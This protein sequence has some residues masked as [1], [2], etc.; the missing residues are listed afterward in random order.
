MSVY[1]YAIAAADT[2]VPESE[3]LHGEPVRAVST[4]ALVAAVST[5]DDHAHLGG[6]SDLWAHEQVVEALMSG[7]DVLPARFGTLLGDDEIVRQLLIARESEFLEALA[8]V[9]GSYEV[10]VRAALLGPRTRDTAELSG[11]EYLRLAAH[12][13]RLAKTLSEQLEHALRPLARA[14]RIR[15]GRQPGRLVESAWLIDRERLAEF[16]DRAAELN[17]STM[18]AELLCTGPWPPYSFVGAEQGE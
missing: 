13:M 5:A 16:R 14:S 18:E 2:P 3:G 6:D 7:G 4:P 11:G 1:L 8:R 15:P 12:E 9:A 10:A 17:A